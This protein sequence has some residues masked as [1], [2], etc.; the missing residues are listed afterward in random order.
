MLDV[1][2][3]RE[4]SCDHLGTEYLLEVN[5]FKTVLQKVVDTIPQTVFWKDR[6]STYR[7][8]NKLFAKIAGKSHPDE[9]IGL[10]DFDLP[11]D[12]E[13]AEFYRECDRRVMDSDTPQI[14]IIESQL[15]AG[16][17]LTW[18]ET[19]KVPLHNDAGDVVGIL[20]TFSDITELKLAQEKLKENNEALEAR[21]A[22]RTQQLQHVAEHDG[23][24]GLANRSFFVRKLNDVLRSDTATTIALLF[25]DLDNFKPVNDT[26][27][28]DS[29]DKLLMEMASILRKLAGPNDLAARFGGDEFLL[30]L[31]DKSKDQLAD[32]GEEIRRRMG[33]QSESA[34][35]RSL[36]TASIGIV[37]CSPGDYANSD[38]LI[39]DADMAMYTAK[40]QGKNAFCFFSDAMRE[41]AEIEVNIEREVLAGISDRQFVL[42]YQPIVDAREKRLTGFEALI[43]WQHPQRGLLYPSS[44]IPVAESTGVI[45][46]LGKQILELACE[47]LAEW[48]QEFPDLGADFKIN[49]NVSPRQ[50]L[51]ADFVATLKETVRRH[52]VE[53]R[54]VGLEITESLLLRDHEEAIRLLLEIRDY[55]FRL[56]LD[57]FGTG[58]SSLN[59]LDDLPVD[60]LKIDRTFITKLGRDYGDHTIVRMI[61]A[62]AKTLD[63]EVVAEGVEN[64]LQLERLD[65]MDCKLIQGYYFAKPL[66][67][68]D[69]TA[70]LTRGELVFGREEELLAV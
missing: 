20:G 65:S 17:E 49:I 32:I 38:D 44:F 70:Y 8:C 34:N 25:I 52:G 26:Q 66:S 23:L 45:V 64:E 16:G 28:Y 7:G 59:Y 11:W 10:T 35:H 15:N 21:V 5:D 54:N 27:G 67:S 48:Q 58:Y 14:G 47:Q 1:T 33:H 9:L 24:T 69:A 63:I 18:L 39:N 37:Q 22:Q 6:D 41:S 53:P 13:E 61:L 36:V 30:L 40:S 56:S 68:E 46:Q 50:L 57:D 19:N 31:V 55:G 42:L 43:R 51:E 3:P 29:G 62:L 4:E 60:T 12:R 2:K